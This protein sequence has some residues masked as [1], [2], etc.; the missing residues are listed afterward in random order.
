MAK[1]EPDI[2]AA[3]LRATGALS[4]AEEALAKAN[5]LEKQVVNLLS[6]NEVL[7]NIIKKSHKLDDSFLTERVKEL[8]KENGTF[9]GR[10]RKKDAQICTGCGKAILK[11][12]HKCM[13]CGG[14]AELSLF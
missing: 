5:R 7:W 8:Q 12:Q 6:I 4:S 1:Y 3:H 14:E 13:Y 9:N 2:D 11:N 10:L